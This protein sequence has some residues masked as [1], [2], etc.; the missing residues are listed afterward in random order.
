VTIGAILAFLTALLGALIKFWP[1][2][3]SAD[4]KRRERQNQINH[5]H[6]EFNETGDTSDLGN[7]P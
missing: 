2:P 6:G 4:Q 5:A 3:K 7:L 1:E